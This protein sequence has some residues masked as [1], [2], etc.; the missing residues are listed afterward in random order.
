VSR[1]GD[2]GAAAACASTLHHQPLLL[3]RLLRR[4]R[5]QRLRLQS[6]QLLLLL[7]QLRLRWRR[8]GREINEHPP[9]Y[10]QLKCWHQGVVAPPQTLCA[11]PA[12][13]SR[14]SRCGGGSEAA[15]LQRRRRWHQRFAGA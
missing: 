2:A 14:A 7:R 8:R 5:L 9:P 3:L 1:E 6:Q 10:H 4:H 12:S 13:R 15:G 11:A